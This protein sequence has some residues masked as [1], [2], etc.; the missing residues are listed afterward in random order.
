MVNIARSRVGWKNVLGTPG[1]STFFSLDPVAFY[2]LVR[3]FFVDLEDYFPADLDWE[4]ESE[5]DYIDP[6]NGDLTGGWTVTP[7]ADVS[8]TLTGGYSAPA[9]AVVHWNT[10]TILDSHKLRGRTYLVP[11]H[12]SQYGNDGQIASSTLS[13]LQA[14]ADAF[15]TA[16]AA[17]FVV[18]HRP[19]DEH[20]GGY[21][22]VTS[23]KVSSKV[24][25]L[26]SRRD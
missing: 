7:L 13:N 23:A 4:F 20:V 14:A 9:G 24:A 2:P 11:I 26:R 8:A 18:W 3:D 19:N 12:G 21:S 5:G 15:V 16:A 25:I 10:G 17:N 22:A 6:L 1:V